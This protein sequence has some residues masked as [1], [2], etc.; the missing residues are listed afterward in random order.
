MGVDIELVVV[1][2]A[3]TS[4]RRRQRHVVRSLG[5]SSDVFARLLG[6][7]THRG[8]TP[9]LDRVDRCGSLEL[10]SDEM[11]LL[12]AELGFMRAQTDDLG[13]LAYLARLSDLARDCALASAS[14]LLFDGD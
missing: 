7:L 11:P 5:D 9:T 1:T 4:P 13:E 6:R 8:R 12:L 2:R 3:G 10:S 14:L